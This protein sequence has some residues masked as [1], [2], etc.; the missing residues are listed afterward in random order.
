LDFGLAKLFHSDNSSETTFSLADPTRFS[1]TVAPELL[2]GDPADI[3]TD[4][5]SSGAVLYEMATGRR[6]YGERQLR[7][8]P[9]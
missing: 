9:S 8:T 5:Y 2:R 6:L 4:I 7:S 3:R 1:G